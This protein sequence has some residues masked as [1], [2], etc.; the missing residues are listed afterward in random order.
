[1]I[2]LKKVSKVYQSKASTSTQAL[3]DVSFQ[4]ENKGMT[5]ILGKSGSGKSTLLHLLGGLDQLTSGEILV[6]NTS[7]N[8]FSKQEWDSYRNTYVGFVFQEF[9]VLESYN[10][11]ENI[12]LSLG[13]QR[14]AISHQE[15]DQLLEKLGK[16]SKNIGGDLCI[17]MILRF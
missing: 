17:V 15:T 11:Y 13:L 5:F 2:E 16:Q 7:M 6:A 1:M 8:D 9:H 12:E 3:Q 14:K 10:V 4:L